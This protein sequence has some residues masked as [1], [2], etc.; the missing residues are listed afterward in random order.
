MGKFNFEA[1]LGS[2]GS[3][4]PRI[5]VRNTG[6][7]GVS[8]GVCRRLRIEDG[9]WYVVLM[10]DKG[11]SAIGLKFTQDAGAKGA[12]RLQK[13]GV[14]TAE[15]MLNWSGHV[16]ARAF[17]DYW[18]IE[19]KNRKQR[20][21]SPHFEDDNVVVVLLNEAQEADCDDQPEDVSGGEVVA[22]T[23]TPL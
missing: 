16:P 15:G 12:V 11:Q 7:L 4:A 5:S 10:Y 2:G 17:L 21:Y 1:F 22:Q 3:Y 20:G 13:R 6:A 19:Y 14:P 23:K 18:S 8:Q 9:D